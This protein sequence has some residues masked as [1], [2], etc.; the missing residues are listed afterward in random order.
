VEEEFRTAELGDERRKKRAIRVASALFSKPG[1]SIPE[2]CGT[3][4][5]WAAA[6]RLIGSEEVSAEQLRAAHA[7]ATVRR[8]LDAS[9]RVLVVQDTTELNF[10]GRQSLQGIGPLD[11]WWQRGLKVHSALAATQKGV[12][13][14]IVHQKV[15]ARDEAWGERR[16]RRTRHTREKESIRWIE[17]L[18]AAEQRFPADVELLVIGDR[19]ADFYEL[20][21]APRR[22][23][24]H[25]LVRAAQNR[26]IRSD[27]HRRLREAAEAAPVWGKMEVKLARTPERAPRV[28][29]LE[30]RV[31][32][33]EIEPPLH[34]KRR[35]RWGPVPV[36]VVWVRE[37]G[38]LPAGEEA[39][40]W[41]L[42]CTE[43]VTSWEQAAGLVQAYTHRWKVERYHYT[44]KSGC[45]VEELQLERADRI[46]RALALFSV[47]AWRLLWMTYHARVQP[48][49]SCTV[50]L[51]PVEWKSLLILTYQ[52]ADLPAEPPTLQ[53]AVRMI[54][55]LGGFTGRK[56]D[57]DPGV[58]TLW[59]GMRQLLAFAVG[60]RVI[61]SP[62]GD[63]CNA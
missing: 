35:K 59:R 19:E 42:L 62:S 47:V 7:D 11:R 30:V 16:H 48:Q 10:T 28:A 13:L 32:R 49:A 36:S 61:A 45:R 23:G 58:K 39:V 27:E 4:S 43:E 15:W 44:L 52:R 25:L 38:I 54:A 12:P 18:H 8:A 37:T 24:S 3:R 55:L 50:A 60:Y 41:V 20:L 5:A 31:T 56:R 9:G 40:D 22:E 53:E 63:V 1:A 34:I 17:T 57:G 46:E 51:D 2:A 26:L 21:A 33:V 6:Y 14:G 29:Q